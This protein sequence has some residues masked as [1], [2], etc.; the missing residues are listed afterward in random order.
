MS[1]DIV[2]ATRELFMTSQVLRA[3]G[4]NIQSFACNVETATRQHSF[5]WKV[6][7]ESEALRHSP[8]RDYQEP[9]KIPLPPT[10]LFVFG[11]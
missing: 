9:S 7:C 5:R 11:N 2:G 1:L 3:E 10:P 8:A 4:N 6:F